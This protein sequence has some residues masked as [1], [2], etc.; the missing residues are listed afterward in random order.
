ME[1]II[2]LQYNLTWFI[3]IDGM[4]LHLLPMLSHCRTLYQICTLSM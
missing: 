3:L 4:V 1:D 2:N